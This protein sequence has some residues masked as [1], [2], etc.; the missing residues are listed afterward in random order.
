MGLGKIKIPNKIAGVI[1]VVC[2]LTAGL[3][4]LLD[5]YDKTDVTNFIIIKKYKFLSILK[6]LG[7]Q[8]LQQKKPEIKEHNFADGHKH[9][10]LG[11][12]H[13]TI[14]DDECLTDDFKYVTYG[15]RRVIYIVK[16]NDNFWNILVYDL[17]QQDL[18]RQL[19]AK[20]L[21]KV[22]DD[23]KD[24]LN[25]MS[26]DELK[27]I[28]ISSGNIN[29]LT[30]GDKINI[31]PLI[32]DVKKIYESTGINLLKFQTSSQYRKNNKYVCWEKV[33]LLRADPD[34][35]TAF[36]NGQAEDKN[37]VYFNWQTLPGA[38][39]DS[40][41]F[42]D[43]SYSLDNESV[44]Y[45]G[46]KINGAD[47]KS[48]KKLIGVYSRDKNSVYAFSTKM[49][50]INPDEISFIGKHLRYKDIVYSG[51]DPIVGVNA[52]KFSSME[53]SFYSKDDKHVYSSSRIMQ[54][55]DP[56]TFKF[57][58]GFYAKDANNAYC[59]G[60]VING[61]DVSTFT[62][63]NPAS[64]SSIAEDKNNIYDNCVVKPKQK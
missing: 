36:S 13:G 25:L 2:L 50:G 37:G 35:F 44:Y 6:N 29:V 9:I 41:I 34:T 4:I 39:P 32:L 31:S 22:L 30:L 38:N 8:Q 33:L 26:S 60:D 56:Q 54:N 64:N 19:N 45:T 15:L 21:N 14:R 1:I 18:V 62:V 57:L 61:A 43:K 59:S 48:F 16:P 51:K 11:N 55:A 7:K 58:G 3:V 17:K 23:I 10:D 52:D 63:A 47:V 20:E 40:L 12:G 5:W 46:E 24:K 27:N 49:E 28:G 42:L 53:D